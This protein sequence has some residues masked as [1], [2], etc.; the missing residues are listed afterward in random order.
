M[1]SIED[2]HGIEEL[3]TRYI[4]AIDTGDATAWVESFTNDGVFEA[5]GMTTSGR[6][7][8]RA[9]VNTRFTFRMT[10]PTVNGQHWISNIEG[11]SNGRRARVRCY[12]LRTVQVRETGEVRLQASGWFDDELQKVEGAWRIRKRVVSKQLPW[13][14]TKEAE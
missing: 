5:N 9:W 13:V 4:W 10:E 1:L 2:R 8:L 7:A 3:Y 6:V 14:F 12:F 11:T